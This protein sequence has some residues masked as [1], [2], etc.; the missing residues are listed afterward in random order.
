MLLTHDAYLL[1]IE[2]NARLA[3]RVLGGLDPTIQVPACPGWPTSELRDHISGVF[4]FWAHQ[5]GRLTTDGPDFP[6]SVREGYRRSILENAGAVL[7]TLRSLGPDQVCW[8]WSGENM[9]SGWA[10]RRLAHEITV[11][12]V[13]AQMAANSSADNQE[14]PA[15]P[16]IDAA[17]ASDGIEEML[18]VHV[19]RPRTVPVPGDPVMRILTPE[20]RW[21]VSIGENVARV[22]AD[23]APDLTISGPTDSVLLY[24]WGRQFPVDFRG[25]S[26]V[27]AAWKALPVFK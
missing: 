15:T 11:H 10:A 12:R 13:D 9:T 22:E 4:A 26:T 18:D 27:F 25:D 23:I 19:G 6:D 24:L 5:L 16:R 3:H 17:L 21:T 7:A 20:D 2:D 1:A 14:L 8:N